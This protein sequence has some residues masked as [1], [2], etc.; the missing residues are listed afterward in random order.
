MIPPGSTAASTVAPDPV[1]RPPT[2]GSG[3]AANGP[4]D[5]RPAKNPPAVPADVPPARPAATP[6]QGEGDHRFPEPVRRYVA[7]TPTSPGEAEAAAWLEEVSQRL[8]IAL[9]GYELQAELIEKRLTPNAA[10]VKFRGSDRMTVARVEKHKDVLYTS[11]QLDVIDVRPGPGEVIV[12]VARPQRATLLLTDLWKRRGL[13][14]SAPWKNGSFLIGERE[15]DGELVY[16][17]L[18][19][20]FGGQPRHGPHTLIAGESGGGK[21]VFT[22]NV[23]LDICAT[24][25]PSTARIVLI[26]PKYG[27]DYLWINGMPHLD[28]GIVVDRQQA[29][30]K[31]AAVVE[32]MENRYATITWVAPDID[33]YNARVSGE[34]KLPRIYVF[35]DEIGDWMADKESGYRD[36]MDGSVG[37]LAQKARAAGIHLFLIT[38]R[39]D[40][41]I[42]TGI[43]KANMNNKV[44]LRVSSR[45]NS[46]IVLDENGGEILLGAGHFAAKLANERPSSQSSLIFGQAPFI[47]DDAAQDLADA[48]RTHW[49][50]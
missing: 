9:R 32:E 24:N 17:N 23:L 26:D 36:V 35:H 20:G 33:R 44:C 29:V 1:P 28:G 30:E 12:M 39:P 7:A 3:V 16:L 22:R 18:I 8:R 46:Q 4:A 5:E 42:V 6:A 50:G 38:Q 11:H 10:L 27:G 40:K 31:L 21:G 37:R 34:E 19:D 15:N 43:I 25:H 2:P 41:D 47:E 45:V 48:I 14:D 13:P 49:G